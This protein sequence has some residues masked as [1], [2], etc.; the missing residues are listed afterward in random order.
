MRRLLHLFELRLNGDEV[1]G[2]R[3]E[4]GRHR[5]KADAEG[6]IYLAYEFLVDVAWSRCYL[7][8]GK[9][10]RG[11]M[12]CTLFSVLL[13]IMELLGMKVT[14]FIRIRVLKNMRE[15]EGEAV[16]MTGDDTVVVQWVRNAT[17]KQ[18]E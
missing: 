14:A 18:L 15:K 9:D 8:L 2:G 10:K 3:G 5:K 17:E 7:S 1:S 13:Y 6:V 11:G 16:L 12:L 4:T